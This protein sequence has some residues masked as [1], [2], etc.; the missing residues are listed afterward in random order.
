MDLF[1]THAKMRYQIKKLKKVN[2][3]A[4]LLGI[5]IGRKYIGFSVTD[6]FITEARVCTYL[7]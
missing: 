5:D 3:V 4:R 1:L 7:S 6:K 2:P